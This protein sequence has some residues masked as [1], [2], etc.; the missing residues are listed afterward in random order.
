MNWQEASSPAFNTSP[1]S[2]VSS[3]TPINWFW[4]ASARREA[5]SCDIDLMFL[6][7]FLPTSRAISVLSGKQSLRLIDAVRKCPSGV[8]SVFK[9]SGVFKAAKAVKLAEAEIGRASCRERV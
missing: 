7:R 9:V 6:L 3:V 5:R 8:V 4:R 1:E 2:K